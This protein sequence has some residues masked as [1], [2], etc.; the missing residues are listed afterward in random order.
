MIGRWKKC[1]PG[2]APAVYISLP[3]KSSRCYPA[4][5]TR[6]P[7]AY[8]IPPRPCRLSSSPFLQR[9]RPTASQ[10]HPHP[11]RRVGVVRAD[12][13]MAV[14]AQHLAHA[15]H[16]HDYSR[17]ISRPAMDDDAA[18]FLGEPAAGH[19]VLR[20]PA[21]PPPQQQRQQVGGNTV[22]SDPRSE[23]TC[24]NN[25]H[26]S[27]CFAP[28][29]RARTGDVADD[30]LTMEG[31]RA[32]LP[33]PQPLAFAPMD[34]EQGRVLCSVDASTS[35]RLPGPGSAPASHSVLSHLYRHS[36]EIDAFVRI[37]V[38]WRFVISSRILL[39]PPAV[40]ASSTI[41]RCDQAGLS[42]A[43]RTR[44]CG[45]GWRR[46]GGGTRAPWCRPWSV[47]R[48]GA[49]GRRRP[50]WSAPWRAARSSGSGS[51]RWAPRARRGGASPAAT[52]P[53]P[54]A[55]APRSSSSSSRRRA[56]GP[57]P[58]PR[59]RGRAASGRRRRA[60]R[61]PPGAGERAGRAA[62]RTRA[63]CCCRAGTCACAA[64]ARRA[65]RRAPCARPPRTPRSTSSC[66][67]S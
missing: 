41:I 42:R 19:L 57:R 39:G 6:P 51:G 7:L 1:R 36:V 29:K 55:C 25:L 11:P 35:G 8:A 4:P 67:D 59:T 43:C 32:L 66:R 52:R 64:G 58:R 20:P 18:A 24:N 45:R 46:R 65:P 2:P 48:R 49:C 22:F 53:R 3:Y 30:G 13:R 47:R 38:R 31:H 21:P 33:V 5:P 34:D 28:R 27:V 40:K 54:R 50:T 61:P 9:H 15:F 44:G 60:P 26:D 10:P 14:Q 23:L 56:R 12:P 37:E 17:A 63:C 16:H 62:R